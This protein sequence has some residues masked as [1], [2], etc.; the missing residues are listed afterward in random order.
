MREKGVRPNQYFLALPLH[1]GEGCETQPV[2]F[3]I[4]TQWGRRVWGPSGSSFSIDCSIIAPWGRRVWGL[5]SSSNFKNHHHHSPPLPP[6]FPIL[7]T[8]YFPLMMSIVGFLS[9]YGQGWCLP[10]LLKCSSPCHVV[11]TYKYAHD[12]L[13]RC[14]LTY[15]KCLIMY[16]NYHYN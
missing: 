6:L 13:A 10:C 8:P 12:P 3:S 5:I 2:L 14:G 7:S 1:E 9:A 16:L 4:A 15:D 11:Y